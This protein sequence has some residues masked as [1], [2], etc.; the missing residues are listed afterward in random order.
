MGV[1]GV[2]KSDY[3]R[4]G[5]VTRRRLLAWGKS[6][7]HLAEFVVV[8]AAFLSFLFAVTMESSVWLPF[9]DPVSTVELINA[10]WPRM[11]IPFTAFY[12]CPYY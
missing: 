5:S 12:H 6:A 2:V 11:F 4:P 3:I 1:P 7:S 10:V 8:A 9:V